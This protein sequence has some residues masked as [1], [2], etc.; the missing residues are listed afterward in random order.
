MDGSTDSA[1]GARASIFQGDLPLGDKLD[2]ARTELLDLSARNRL[3]SVPRSSKAAKTV[4]VV[5][6]KS[7][8]VFQ[9][10]VR[11][12]RPLTFVPGK[13]DRDGDDAEEEIAGEVVMPVDGVEE[14]TDQRSLKRLQTRMTP[15]GLQ[16]RLLD[17]H[18]DARTLEEEQG[19]NI[20]FLVLG[21]LKWTDPGN[22]AN[23]RHAPL[24]LIPVRL[25]RAAAGQRFKLRLRQEEMAPNLSLEAYLDRVHGLRMPEADFGDDFD[26]GAYLTA[27]ADAVSTKADWEV[28]ADDVILGFFSFAKFLMYRDLDPAAW[29]ADGALTDRPLIRGLLADGFTASSSGISE[30]ESID[31]HIPPAD[32]LHI[33][34][35][36]SSQAL[37]V[38]DVRNGRDLVIQGPPGT[39]KSQTIANVIAAAVADG[40]TVLFVAEKMT[41]LEVVKRRLDAA[42]VGEACLELHSNKANKR[43]LLEEL[44][45]TWDL[46]APRGDDGSV[47]NDRL[48]AVRDALNGHVDRMHR[49]HPA[50]SLTPFEVI[51][52]L[53][54]LRAAG[55]VPTDLTLDAPKTWT[56]AQ[57]QDREELVR[58]LAQRIVD[59]GP[60]ASH[61]WRG[62]GLDFVLPTDLERTLARTASLSTRLGALVAA[63]GVLAGDLGLEAP[64]RRADLDAV[65][66]LARRLVG[67]PPLSGHALGDDVWDSRREEVK[68]LVWAGTMHAKFRR[69]LVG[70]ALP[71]AW[72]AELDGARAVLSGL[73]PALPHAALGRAT[74]LAALLPRLSVE[75]Q[76]LRAHLGLAGEVDSA[77]AITDAITTADR[78]AVAPDASPTAFAAAVWDRGL[79]QA[80]DLAEAVARLERAKAALRGIVT[81]AVWDMDLRAA[82]QT[83]ATHG[84][85]MLKALSGEWRRA[86]GLV[87]S[88]LVK[89]DMALP[90]VL[91]SLDKLS[92]GRAAAAAVH[93]DDAFGRAAFGEDW[94]GERSSAAPLQALV[95]WMGSLRGLGAEPRLIAG[96]LPDR[97][98]IAERAA[99]V[100]RLL[101]QARPLLAALWAD[102]GVDAVATFGGAPSAER[103]PLAVV[104]R[105]CSGASSAAATF[106]TA[107]V[108]VPD[109]AAGKV[110]RLDQVMAG[111]KAAGLVRDGEDL[112][113][114]A[115]GPAWRGL[116]SDWVVL[117]AAAEWL[118]ANGDVR[119]L[120]AG[121]AEPRSHASRAEATLA[122]ADAFGRDLEALFAGLKTDVSVLF[123]APAWSGVAYA[124]LD[125]RMSTWLAHGED[126]SK[127]VAFRERAARGRASGIGEVVT[128][129]EDG[130]LAPDDAVA[131]YE[132]AYYEALFGDQARAA[133]EIARFDGLFHEGLRREFAALDNERI[134]LA[135]REVARA[136]HRRIPPPGGGAGPLG[137]LRSEIARRRGHMP[138]R[139]LMTKAGPVVQALKPVMMMSPLSVAQ[140]LP[141]GRLKFDLLVM[142]EASQIQPVDALGAI[143]RCAKVVVVGDE[144]QLPPTRFFSRVTGGQEAEDEDGAQVADIESILG[145]FIARGL[146]QRMLRWHY[147]SRHQSLIAVSNSQFY[148]NRLYIVPSPYT[149]EA[150]M[151]LR[152]HHV[153]D[154]VFDSGGTSVNAIEADVRGEGR[155]A[156][157]Q[158]APGRVARRR[159]V[160]RRT[161]AGHPGSSST[162]CRR[163]P[164]RTRSS[165][166]T[167]PSRSS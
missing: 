155:A 26:P 75:A 31:P 16:K 110:A 88:V 44:R 41:A 18:L 104:S 55:R 66:A 152:F 159:D 12:D 163:T 134:A 64:T 32:M 141:P 4:E 37:A 45:R 95:A 122:E 15:K 56:A 40:K 145:L 92:E 130:R 151:G 3:L 86:N 167:P 53:T 63:Q 59:I 48:L 58:D 107:F 80:G 83:L 62:V 136:H 153:P 54:R 126:L 43:G 82:R 129:L 30:D 27:V 33:V 132:M 123:S 10:L 108:D 25:E 6:A 138:I 51:G 147:R 7:A 71:A 157:R 117:Q 125:G 114:A 120:A 133:P 47:L 99:N 73:P 148:Q 70:V 61:P 38:H 35:C 13:A 65:A 112:G 24:I 146:P 57:R 5:G 11:E 20:L 17:L 21:T 158:G 137:V 60:P 29:P 128:S 23:A 121:L 124:D 69:L 8:D 154:G 140:F 116:A 72:D 102:L 150:G 142:D 79:D 46:G 19:T 118:G 162:S 165:S 85:G 113:R 34:D 49:R 93:D 103:V 84:T 74:Q 28:V 166:P 111:Q 106:A 97:S 105:W 90:E 9:M 131:A 127:W 50:A 109:D 164:A 96:R 81:D 14:A 77:K 89:S 78:V 39:G 36:D 139:Q 100:G 98:Q 160:L 68:R 161:A 115:F 144:R 52:H 94:R 91:S 42:G 1:D 67:T 76:G 22:A 143:A 101:D 119:M 149:D 156:S 2:R 87:R 135:Q